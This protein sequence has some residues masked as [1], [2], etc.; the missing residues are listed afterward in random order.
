MI[1]MQNCC[2]SYFQYIELIK[3]LLPTFNGVEVR[4]LLVTG[5]FYNSSSSPLVADLESSS[6]T[7]LVVSNISQS[8]CGTTLDL[9]L[10]N[11]LTVT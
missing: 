9:Q 8:G 7:P 2:F 3:P 4:L 11:E 5:C 6:I 1:L 10:V